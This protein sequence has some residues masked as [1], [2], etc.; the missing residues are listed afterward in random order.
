M[1]HIFFVFLATNILDTR[2]TAEDRS[3]IIVKELSET[4]HYELWSWASGEQNNL[5]QHLI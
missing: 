1:N 4:R 5:R 3:L 2:R